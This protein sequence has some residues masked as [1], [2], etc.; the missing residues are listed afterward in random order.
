MPPLSKSERIRQLAKDGVPTADIARTLG[1]RYQHAYNVL[2][3][4]DVPTAGKSGPSKPS[5]PGLSKETLLSHGFSLAAE[6]RL[7]EDGAIY[8]SA[9]LPKCEGVYAFS[10]DA[11]VQYV[12]VATMGLARRLYHYAKPGISQRTSIRINGVI[13]DLLTGGGAVE[14]LYACPDHMEWNGLPVHGS[15]GLELGL[16]KTFDLPWNQRSAK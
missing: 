9:A 16:I 15:A 13:R 10:M 14:I 8:L 11:I 6:W 2:K 1:I 4:T 5:K 12:G 3:N 7:S